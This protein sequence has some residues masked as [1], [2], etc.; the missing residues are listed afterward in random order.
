MEWF[1]LLITIIAF[2]CIW[3]AINRFQ[4]EQRYALFLKNINTL[5]GASNAKKLINLDH[6]VGL[7]IDERKQRIIVVRQRLHFVHQTFA[8]KDLISAHICEDGES[9]ISTDRGSQLGGALVGGLLLGGVGAV[10]GGLSGKQKSN[11]KVKRVDLR[12][13]MN[14]L[15]EPTVD[16]RIFDDTTP[17]KKKEKLTDILEKAQQ[18]AR[19]WLGMLDVVIKRSTVQTASIAPT[20]EHTNV[21]D[22]I[23]DLHQLKTEGLLTEEEYNEQ[24]KIALARN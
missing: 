20:Q 11:K 3:N 17:L 15:D 2:I 1:F 13:T 8:F 10:I 18:T 16:I 23:K 22:K 9:V 5:P 12:I 24:K 21:V 14:C 7:L 6:T 4:K 19:H